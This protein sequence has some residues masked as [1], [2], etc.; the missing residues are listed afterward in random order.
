MLIPHDPSHHL[1]DHLVWLVT[2]PQAPCAL[3]VLGQQRL[4]LDCLKERLVHLL[5]VRSPVR[6]GLLLLALALVEEGVLAAL[7]VRLL[8]PREVLGLADLVYCLLVEAVD[9]NR[10]RGGDNVAGVDTS[11]GHAV[12]FEWAGDE[13]DTLVEDLKEY[14][15]LA[16]EA[17]S[18]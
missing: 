13:E 7:L 10:G 14:D 6:A 4:L 17:T 8:V 16:A 9:S 11:D 12:D 3:Q 5:L 15:T 18:E 2:L 1:K